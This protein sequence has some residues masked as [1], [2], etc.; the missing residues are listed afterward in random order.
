MT[1]KES[2]E[3]KNRSSSFR[4]R[5][6]DLATIDKFQL[7]YSPENAQLLSSTKRWP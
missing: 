7:G 4:Q 3:G 5:G 6:Y 1:T 2:S